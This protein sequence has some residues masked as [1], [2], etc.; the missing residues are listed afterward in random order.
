MNTT[1]LLENPFERTKATEYTDD[2]IKN[3]W[4]DLPNGKDL[5]RP[6]SPTPIVVRGSKGSG[7]THLLRYC[8]YQIQK[9]T[10]GNDLR[11]AVKQNRYLGIYFRGKDINVGRF[12][13]KGQPASVWADV[14]PYYLDLWLA[15]IT[16]GALIDFLAGHESGP[17]QE[18]RI[19]ADAVK[20]FVDFP[21]DPPESLAAL[22]AILADFRREVDRQVNNSALTRTLSVQILSTKGHLVFGV[23]AAAAKHVP[24][25]AS[26][27]FLYL[28]DE[29]EELT[30]D[31]QKYLQTLMRNRADPC[32]FRL[33]VRLY[34]LRTLD[35]DS[36]EQNRAGSEFEFLNLDQMIRDKPSA[37]NDF[38]R[39][40]CQ[41]RLVQAGFVRDLAKPQQLDS[42]F[43]QVQ[44]GKHHVLETAPLVAK[45][46]D[47]ERPY[48]ARLKKQLETAIK[49]QKRPKGVSDPEQISE[50]IATLKCDE[51]PLLEKLNILTFYQEWYRSHDLIAAAKHVQAACREFIE[52]EST[53]KKYAQRLSH[54]K[55]DLLAQLYSECGGKRPVYAGLDT[56]VEMSQGVP[57]YLLT[58]LKNIFKWSVFYGEQPFSS[59]PISLRAQQKGIADSAEWFFEDAQSDDAGPAVRN[60]VQRLAELFREVRF[61]DKPSECSLVTFS[62]DEKDVSAKCR[63]AIEQ[64]EN[65]SFLIHVPRGQL[66]R[67]SERVDKKYQ[68]NCMLA[69]KWGLPIA[70]RGAIKL[71]TE[72]MNSIFDEDHTQQF[73]KAMKRRI[74]EMQAPHFGRDKS[75][76]PTL[77]LDLFDEPPVSD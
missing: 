18:R 74:Q 13:D 15:E 64:T 52:T 76:H 37:Y 70:R 51:Y 47:R 55:S 4:V 39:K 26:T 40:L 24:E 77:A 8:S 73:Q 44:A 59:H 30:I 66:D 50:V 53:P 75:A 56:F 45:F 1:P 41:Q 3:Y 22:K 9:A 60:C 65:W 43:Q 72:L 27:R 16:I 31:Q 12:R 42:F 29:I 34:G 14:Y 58:T 62:F 38:A 71:S 68:L 49:G 19:C 23:P 46:T 6:M 48:F 28:I 17:A 11:K 32:S 63:Q 2:Q 25:L 69:P 7:K 61:S 67:N 57:R 5:L 35:T 20:C 21:H 54:F 36:G 33:G 10:H